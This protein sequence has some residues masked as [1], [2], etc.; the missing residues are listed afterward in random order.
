MCHAL[1]LERENERVGFGVCEEREVY[2]RYK[3]KRCTDHQLEEEPGLLK[4]CFPHRARADHPLQCQLFM[5]QLHINQHRENFSLHEET[6]RKRTALIR[7]Q[8]SQRFLIIHLSLSG[9]CA[10]TF[11]G[12]GCFTVSD[13]LRLRW[14]VFIVDAV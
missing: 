8:Q 13:Q 12:F 5:E 10:R 2:R 4:G 7:I 14:C 3:C 11:S 6:R 9:V 1:C